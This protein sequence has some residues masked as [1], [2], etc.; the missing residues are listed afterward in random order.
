MAAPVEAGRA[1]VVV[2]EEYEWVQE[3]PPTSGDIFDL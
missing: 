3:L 2:A 1:L